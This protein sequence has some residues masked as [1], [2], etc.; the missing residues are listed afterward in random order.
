MAGVLDYLV[1]L[2]CCGVLLGPH[3]LLVIFVARESE[4]ERDATQISLGAL[5]LRDTD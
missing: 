1:Y 3:H 4:R 2:Y 5:V